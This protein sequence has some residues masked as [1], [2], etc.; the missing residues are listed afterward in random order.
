MRCC[1]QKTSRRM[2]AA[3]IARAKA[4]I[5]RLVLPHDAVRSRRWSVDPHGMRI[6]PRAT[7][8][9]SIR[10]GGTRIDLALRAPKV[11]HPPIVALLRH[12]R[13]DERLHAHIPCISCIALTDKRRRVHTLLFGTRPHERDAIAESQGHRRGAI[14]VLGG[15]AG[16]VWWHTHRGFAARV[17]PRLVAPRPGTG[18]DRVVLQ[19][20]T[21]ARRGPEHT[22]RQPRTGAPSEIMPS[23]HLAQPAPALT[24]G[25]RPKR[26]AFVRCYRM[27]TSFVPSTTCRA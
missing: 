3:E 22:R 5:A 10:A 17:Q 27:S 25:S 12:F 26:S 1:A 9:R 7:F 6:D 19:R 13:L 23:P 24:T 11:R 21:R 8:R 4:L 14:Q 15:R 16:L 20:W 18:R 2:S